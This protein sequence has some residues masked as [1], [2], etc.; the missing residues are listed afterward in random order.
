MTQ[1]PGGLRIA[2]QRLGAPRPLP[3]EI[4]PQSKC[5]QCAQM[6]TVLGVRDAFGDDFF[7]LSVHT[8]EHVDV[9]R[10]CHTTR[11]FVYR[12]RGSNEEVADPRPAPPQSLPATGH[13]TTTRGTPPAAEPVYGRPEVPSGTR[14]QSE[15]PYARAARAEK[16]RRITEA[17]DANLRTSPNAP[18]TPQ[19]VHDWLR[20]IDMATW[21][22]FAAG[23]RV[24]RPSEATIAGVL[25]VYQARAIQ[26]AETAQ[27]Q[28]VAP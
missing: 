7:Y 9:D 19:A 1:R 24:N 3:A 2:P 8:Y 6:I 11:T 12:C 20:G 21:A 26:A 4:A 22:K 16:V 10:E 23:I 15:S 27:R 14:P 5:P 28:A 18:A 25:A 13:E 17:I